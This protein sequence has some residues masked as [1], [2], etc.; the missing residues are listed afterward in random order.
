[1]NP[2]KKNIEAIASLEQEALH[3]RTRADRVSD[4]VTKFSGS[5][6]FVV[7][8]VIWFLFWIVWNTGP[9]AFDRFPFELLTM[10]VSLEAIFLSTFVLITQNRMTKQADQRAHLDLQINLLA[11]EEM[12]L[13][14][15][16]LRRIC[17][18]LK[19]E[20]D[21][22]DEAIALTKKTDPHELMKELQQKLPE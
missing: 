19:I 14:L 16:L 5:T 12:T 13:V 18:H 2:A 15:R 22:S 8:H 20:L 17:T 21:H 9:L 4:A 3:K 7:L 11:E 6:T 10:I 1:V